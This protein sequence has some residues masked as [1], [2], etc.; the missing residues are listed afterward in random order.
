[1]LRSR[2]NHWIR[3]VG[4]AA[5]LSVGCAAQAGSP[6]AIS[7]IMFHPVEEP[8]FNADGTPVLSLYNDVHEYLE[9]HNFGSNSVDLSAWLI[10]GGIDYSF[11]AGTVVPAQAYRVIAKDPARLA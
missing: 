2:S 3:L 11:P 4:T 9:L 6:V 1:M 5:I 7:E 10:T 8:A